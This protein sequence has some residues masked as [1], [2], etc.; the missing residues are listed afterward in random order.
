M[1]ERN[2]WITLRSLPSIT[3][4]FFYYFPDFTMDNDMDML[5]DD[6][7]HLLF[8]ESPPPYEDEAASP[9]A[10]APA[11]PEEPVA[12]PAAPAPAPPPPEPAL[13]PPPPPPP[14]APRERRCGRRARTP[15]STPRR[16]RRRRAEDRDRGHD[17]RPLRRRSRS[18]SPVDRRK[19]IQS[20]VYFQ[21]KTD[22][23][24][25]STVLSFLQGDVTIV[26]SRATLEETVNSH[27]E[28]HAHARP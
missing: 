24:T 28:E 26:V 17:E 23:L 25:R 10:D 5:D 19:Y 15:P 7:L 21:F 1:V 2:E 11:P 12:E 20:P 3:N 13:P 4:I 22:Q 9:P 14:P 6:H 8:A 18:R 27:A 16:E